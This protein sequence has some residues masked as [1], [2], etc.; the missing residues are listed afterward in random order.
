VPSV[1]SQTRPAQDWIAI[2]VPAIVTPEREEAARA[3][4]ARNRAAF[5][6]RPPTAH[7]ALRGLLF[8]DRC[9]RR[10]GGSMRRGGRRRTY[11]HPTSP[12]AETCPEV[13]RSY[14]ADALEAEV[15]AII[16]AA[17][18]DPATLKR[19]VEAYEA[20]RGATDVEL[21]SR[22][23]HLQQQI[24]RVRADEARLIGLIVA[25][26]EQQDIVSARLKELAQRRGALA[27]QL[28][29]AEARALQHGAAPE[30]AQIDAICAKARRGLSKLDDRDWERLLRDVADEIRL[31]SDRLIEIHGVLRDVAADVAKLS[32]RR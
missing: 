28:R 2:Q 30:A 20:R 9:H 11:M 29:E 1:T 23:A 17:L 14:G 25:D 8:C 12:A 26:R 16:T 15:R 27:G 4:L 3:Q 22:I 21:R 32:H 19:G 6:G 31:R 10:Y 13:Y 18:S 5:T 24:G 7:Y